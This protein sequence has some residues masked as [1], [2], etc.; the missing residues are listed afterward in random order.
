[1]GQ[2]QFDPL[3]FPDVLANNDLR[4]PCLAR[5]IGLIQTGLVQDNDFI[6]LG[7]AHALIK[8]AGIFLRFSVHCAS[9]SGLAPV[10]TSLTV[11]SLVLSVW[12]CLVVNALAV[13]MLSPS[14]T[15]GPYRVQYGQ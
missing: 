11:C 2:Q 1:M 6:L 14:C 4:M 5:D 9:S 13:M 7:G 15:I 3:I 8:S 12:S 10:D